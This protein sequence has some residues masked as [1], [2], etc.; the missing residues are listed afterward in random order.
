MKPSALLISKLPNCTFG[1]Y[2]CSAGPNASRVSGAEGAGA[3]PRKN[4]KYSAATLSSVANAIT[5]G[6]RKTPTDSFSGSGSPDSKPSRIFVPVLSGPASTGESTAPVNWPRTYAPE[7]QEYHTGRARI[8]RYGIQNRQSQK[9]R[10]GLHREAVQ[11]TR[12]SADTCAPVRGAAR[13]KTQSTGGAMAELQ[14]RF[15]GTKIRLGDGYVQKN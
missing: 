4:S 10:A 2:A 11:S 5:A 7:R 1:A 14:C 13:K 6:C 15:R 9:R 12:D 3:G 8:R